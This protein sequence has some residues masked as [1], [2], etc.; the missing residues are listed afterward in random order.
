M[1]EIF[2]ADPSCTIN[3]STMSTRTNSDCNPLNP[4][5]L[6]WT[7]Y[8]S[9]YG[10]IT[11][12]NN[13]IAENEIGSH[14]VQSSMCWRRVIEEQCCSINSGQLLSHQICCN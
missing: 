3:A 5:V 12:T 10:E 13:T 6:Y 8:S 4:S 7:S 11:A 2:F 9:Q 1:K 14:E